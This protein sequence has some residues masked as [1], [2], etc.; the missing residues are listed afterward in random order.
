MGPF[1]DDP[2]FRRMSHPRDAAGA[3]QQSL[4]SGV[5]VD[6][7]QRLD[8][9]QPPR[10]RGRRRGVGDACRRAHAWR[11]SSSARDPDTDVALMRI[12]PS[13]L[14]D[15]PA[16]RTASALSVGDF[17]VAVGNPFGS[18]Q[19]VTSGIVSA[20]GRSGLP[21]AGLPEL[22]PDRRVDQ[23]GQFRRRPGQPATANW[24]ASTPPASIRRA[25]WPATSAWVSRFPS[26]LARSIKDQLVANG[27]VHP[28]H[29]GPGDAGP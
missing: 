13:N 14:T 24:S 29:P 20:V 22:H 26:N 1:A 2:V 25:R 27:V 8:P 19:T 17:V 16:G 12:P 11:R 7:K 28:R 9:H 10:D 3:H 6:A 4:G 15:D 23:P 5:I 21:R 18:G